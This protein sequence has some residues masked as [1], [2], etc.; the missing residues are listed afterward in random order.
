MRTFT[1]YTKDTLR[2]KWR[3]GLIIW[4]FDWIQK[5][6]NENNIGWFKITYMKIKYWWLRIE[7]Q[8]GNDMLFEMCSNLENDSEKTCYVC[9]RKWKIR[10]YM[11]RWTCLCWKHNIIARVKW[12]YRKIFYNIK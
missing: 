8:W 9:G 4:Y 5:Y 7:R 12:L 6:I 10:T 3:D 11:F 1:N 2:F